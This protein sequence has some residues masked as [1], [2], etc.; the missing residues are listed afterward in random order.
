MEYGLASDAKLFIRSKRVQIKDCKKSKNSRL[1]R[2]KFYT[3]RHR[4]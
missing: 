1:A 3:Y 4:G 2:L